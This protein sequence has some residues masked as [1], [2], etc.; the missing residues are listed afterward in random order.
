[1]FAVNLASAV[2][3]NL[4]WHPN[5]TLAVLMLMEC[6]KESWQR[7]LIAAAAKKEKKKS[8][9]WKFINNWVRIEKLK[10]EKQRQ[11]LTIKKTFKLNCCC[12]D[13]AT[14]KFCLVL[15]DWITL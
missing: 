14:E 10:R 1:M 4:Y 6:T 8:E 9:W 11:T 2:Y 7:W 15:S 3:T 12:H 13:S 5:D